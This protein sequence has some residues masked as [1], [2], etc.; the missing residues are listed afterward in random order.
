MASKEVKYYL[1]EE[2]HTK[3]AEIRETDPILFRQMN[4]ENREHYYKLIDETH[5]K[6][7]H[8]IKKKE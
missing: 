1:D 3:R 7:K 5:K 4:S 6:I 2:H 8:K